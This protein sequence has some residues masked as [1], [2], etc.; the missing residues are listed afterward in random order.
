M[1]PCIFY[2][3]T[4]A[5]RCNALQWV[6]HLVIF[7]VLT[8]LK[9]KLKKRVFSKRDTYCAIVRTLMD[10]GASTLF[11]GN[12][13]TVSFF[14]CVTKYCSALQ[15]RLGPI[16]TISVFVVCAA[17]RPVI[18]SGGIAIKKQTRPCFLSKTAR[19]FIVAAAV[20]VKN[21]RFRNTVVGRRWPPRST[22]T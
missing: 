16:R 1:R 13:S 12:M 19:F 4:M 6:A 9:F 2:S 8:A 5:E 14:L 18:L 20:Q 22:H 21:V 17:G 7:I 3:R 11:L 10:A 15:H